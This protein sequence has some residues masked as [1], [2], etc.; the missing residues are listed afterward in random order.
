MEFKKTTCGFTKNDGLFYLKRRVVL[1]KTTGRFFATISSPLAS[2]GKDT[3]RG[4]NKTQK[5]RS[6]LS[7]LQNTPFKVRAQTTKNCVFHPQNGAKKGL[8]FLFL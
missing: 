3:K 1:H 4:L 7:F 5:H 2:L 6:F 8:F